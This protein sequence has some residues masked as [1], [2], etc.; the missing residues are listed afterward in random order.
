MIAN[1]FIAS[2]CS[3]FVMKPFIF[4]MINCVS[5]SKEDPNEISI[6]LLNSWLYSATAEKEEA[7]YES[8]EWICR[9]PWFT[10]LAV[11]AQKLPAFKQI[12]P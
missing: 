8:R 4:A 1:W 5:S 3:F 11:K 10:A 7:K 6:N 2:S 12:P 9:R